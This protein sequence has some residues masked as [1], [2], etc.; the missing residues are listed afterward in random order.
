MLKQLIAFATKSPISKRSVLKQPPISETSA[1]QISYEQLLGRAPIP[2]Q[3][4]LLSASI[5]N[6]VVLV[7]GA[8][9]SIG[10]ELCQQI[11]RLE[12]KQLVALELNEYALYKLDAQI[13]LQRQQE[14][15]ETPFIALLGNVQNQTKLESIIK[16]FGIDTLYHA[17]A[18][19]H[20]PLVEQNILEG[21][22]NNVFGTL[23]VA[24]AAVNQGVKRF[25]HVSTDK[26][27]RPTSVMGASKRLAEK[28]IQLE[29]RN[30]NK[31]EPTFFSIVRFGNVLGTSGSV[32]PL[33]KKQISLGGPLTVTH[34][35]ATR[36]FM[37][38]AEAALLV[39][40]AGSLLCAHQAN[41]AQIYLLDMGEPI[42]VLELAERLAAQQGF[43]LKSKKRP[44]G[45]LQVHFTGLRPGEKLYEELSEATNFSGT[46]H[47]KI[48]RVEEEMPEPC[49][50]ASL[51]QMQ[52]ADL[53][54]DPG[55]ALM[56]LE[57]ALP[58]FKAAA[59]AQDPCYEERAAKETSKTVAD[60]T[61]MHQKKAA[62]R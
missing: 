17:A 55:L 45:D 29:A 33:F 1:S 16:K 30:Q 58:G 44:Q 28:I 39:I 61:K 46:S 52:E 26:A 42:K 51:Q 34:P 27:V 25:I 3:P 49:L 13:K 38:P 59:R 10:S 36:Y 12:P 21:I 15:L 50:D 43:T 48:L 53:N 47:A 19:K 41:K 32:V 37:T 24:R 14:N 40:Q 62:V 2:P 11:L 54:L 57:Q 4:E 35:E 8:G 31:Q 56:A 7:T 22:N 60:F 23:A 9:G 18:Y 20:V 5:K 6:K